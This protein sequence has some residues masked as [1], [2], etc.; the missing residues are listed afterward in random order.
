MFNTLF[1][2]AC[3]LITMISLVFHVYHNQKKFFINHSLL[4]KIVLGIV[5]GL[6]GIILMINSY[7]VSDLFIVDFRN[8]AL[9]IAAITGGSISALIAGILIVLYRILLSGLTTITIVL[10]ISVSIQIIVYSVIAYHIKN[11]RLAWTLQYLFNMINSAIVFYYMLHHE[12]NLNQLYYNFFIGSTVIAVL[13]YSLLKYYRNFDTKLNKLLEDSTTDYLT[14]IHNVRGFDQEYNKAINWSTRKNERLSFLMLDIDHFK[15]I[16]DNYGHSAGDEILRQ[17]AEILQ[18]T[19]RVF[20]IISRNGGE[21]F[22]VILQDT[23][24][25]HASEV[26]ERIRIAVEN[27]E[28]IIGKEKIR[29]TISIGCSSY[30]ENTQ[31]PDELI[32]LAD[33][34]LYKA[35]ESGRNR[36]I[37]YQ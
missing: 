22:S 15:K 26:A 29:L 3:I 31:N 25:S 10:I 2:N 28:F 37:V 30:P 1:V 13:I 9:A 18:S 36:V 20:D 7:N 16:N 33:K 6:T 17:L 4:T 12:K 24:L 32:S 34:A 8:F 27:F 5:G 23:P 19:C 14:G 21:E 35:K 11:L